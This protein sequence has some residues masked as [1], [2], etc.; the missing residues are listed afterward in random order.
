MNLTLSEALA[1]YKFSISDW[2]VVDVRMRI[3]PFS[4]GS[5]SINPHTEYS[6]PLLFMRSEQITG[7]GISFILEVWKGFE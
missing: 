3:P 5:D 1:T 6:N 7:V 2:D 4:M